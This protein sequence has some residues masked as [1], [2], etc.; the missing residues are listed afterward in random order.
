[1]E[2]Q[3]DVGLLLDAYARHNRSRAQKKGTQGALLE[4]LPAYTRQCLVNILMVV[5][6]KISLY[7]AMTLHM[8]QLLFTS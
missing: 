5:F 3:Y 1:M 4:M 2:P 6:A 7:N 8:L